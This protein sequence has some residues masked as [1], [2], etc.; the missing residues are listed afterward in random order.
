MSGIKLS[1]SCNKSA[2]KFQGLNEREKER[3]RERGRQTDRQ[4]D[5]E[6]EGGGAPM[7]IYRGFPVR[8]VYLKHDV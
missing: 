4:T 5:R 7:H 8:M 2:T 6:R 1:A 3:E